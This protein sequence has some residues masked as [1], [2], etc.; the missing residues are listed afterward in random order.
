MTQRTRKLIGTVAMLGLIIVY[1]FIA[2]AV[3]VVLQV[4]NAN[5]IVELIF[6]VVAGLLW[7][8]PAGVI[9]KWMQRSDT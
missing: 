9:I 6:Y 5:K 3:A 1:A 8:L 4:Q 7:V 2:L